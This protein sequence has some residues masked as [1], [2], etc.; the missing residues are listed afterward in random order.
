MGR[1]SNCPCA[2]LH[3]G[4]PSGHDAV[5]KSSVVSLQVT[6]GRQYDWS[7][8]SYLSISQGCCCSHS[9][10]LKA[11]NL[12]QHLPPEIF[13]LLPFAKAKANSLGAGAGTTRVKHAESCGSQRRWS[14]RSFPSDPSQVTFRKMVMA[15]RLRCR[16]CWSP[17]PR[18]PWT[19]RRCC[20][21]RRLE[22]RYAM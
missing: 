3:R 20:W 7:S 1:T 22:S 14:W 11:C 4:R 10:L 21:V 12:I 16:S 8:R 6:L 15:A 5:M 18:E 19:R 2:M 13:S 17:L 9:H